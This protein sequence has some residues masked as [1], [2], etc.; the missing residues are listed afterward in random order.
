M[1]HHGDESNEEVLIGEL[2]NGKENKD[3]MN[4]N[5]E[6]PVQESEVLMEYMPNECMD[7]TLEEP[8]NLEPEEPRRRGKRWP[9]NEDTDDEPRMEFP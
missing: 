2:D 5:D 3:D 1:D 6:I 9:R 8:M 7:P 4:Y